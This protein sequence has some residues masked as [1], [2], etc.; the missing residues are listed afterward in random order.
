MLH[1][2]S[3]LALASYSCGAEALG[4]RLWDKGC[5]LHRD[6]FRIVLQRLLFA[7]RQAAS[8]YLT[9]QRIAVCEY[10]IPVDAEVPPDGAD[11]IRQLL[12]LEPSQRLGE[13]SLMVF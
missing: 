7:R 3:S 12:V 1:D 6:T 5:R 13:H 4:Q 10:M 2:G 9:F 8:E 11:L